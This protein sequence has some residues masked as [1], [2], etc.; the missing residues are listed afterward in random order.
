M[1]FRQIRRML[2]LVMLLTCWTMLAQRNA[3]SQTCCS[4]ELPTSEAT[5]YLQPYQDSTFF[6]GLYEQTLYGPAYYDN[7]A[8][9]EIPGSDTGQNSCSF[10][11]IFQASIPKSSDQ[12]VV[13][14]P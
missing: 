1:P 14:G 7:S 2:L 10:R 5:Q 11:A 6:G 12:M 3:V 4:K 13:P 9:E 8:V